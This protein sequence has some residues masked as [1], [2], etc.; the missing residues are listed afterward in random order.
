MTSIGDSYRTSKR[1]Q[2][3]GN[4][5]LRAQEGKA[6]LQKPSRSEDKSIPSMENELSKDMNVSCT[7]HVHGTATELA[8]CL[9]IPMSNHMYWA[10][11]SVSLG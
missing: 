2:M 7:V 6:V 1:L 9:D 10:A 11:C 8:Y 4:L 5:C 3:V